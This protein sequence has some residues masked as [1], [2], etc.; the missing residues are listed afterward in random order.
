[1]IS[2]LERNVTRV[3]LGNTGGGVLSQISTRAFAVVLSSLF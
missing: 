3:A 1:M 2:A